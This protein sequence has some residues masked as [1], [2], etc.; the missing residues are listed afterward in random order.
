[1]TKFKIVLYDKINKELEKIE[2]FKESEFKNLKQRLLELQQGY[3]EGEKPTVSVQTFIATD[4]MKLAIAIAE[5]D[6]DF[7]YMA[8][9]TYLNQLDKLKF[10]QFA[11]R[12]KLNKWL[13]KMLSK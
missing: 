5:S 8:V 13:D 7:S 9:I 2:N 1:M 11:E 10:F 4:G 6:C 12:K 3:C